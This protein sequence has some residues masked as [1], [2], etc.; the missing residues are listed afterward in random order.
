MK[1]QQMLI[2]KK[3]IAI[4]VF[5]I[6][7]IISVNLWFYRSFK[8]QAVEVNEYVKEQAVTR[9]SDYYQQIN[10]FVTGNVNTEDFERVQNLS[11]RELVY[12]SQNAVNIVKSLNTT[13]RASSLL[14][15]VYIYLKKPGLIICRS[16]I[17][18][19][20][21]FYEIEGKTR[22][23]SFDEWQDAIINEGKGRKFTSSENSVIFAFAA[24][25]IGIDSGIVLGTITS[26]EKIFPKTPHVEWINNCNI[27]VYD[28][29]KN[30]SLY[31]ENI[32]I[33]DFTQIPSY[34]KLFGISD[35]YVLY[36]Y[37]V[38][39]SDMT[40]NVNVVFE[41]N[42]DMNIV[43]SVQLVL[44]AMMAFLILSMMYFFYKIYTTR[45]RPI[46]EI[47]DLLG[48]D[49]DK[50]DYRVLE[51]PIKSIVDKNILLNNMLEDKD[52]R[53]KMTILNGLLNGDIKKDVLESED[54]GISFKF[55]GFVVIVINLYRD[56]EISEEEN[57]KLIKKFE[58][59]ITETISDENGITY[60]VSRKQYLVCIYNTDKSL[61][62]NWLGLKFAYLTKILETEFEFVA[63]IAI[64]DIHEGYLQIPMAYSEALE[65]IN[66]VELF[67]KSK[68][69][70]YRDV[71]YKNN[72]FKFDINDEIKL[73]KAIRNGNKNAAEKIIGNVIERIDSENT[74]TYTNIS[75][76]LIY[77]LMRIADL[78][79]GENY[80]TSSISLLLKSTEDIESLKASLVD[81]AAKMCD[82]NTYS[83]EQGDLAEIIMDYVR[84]NYDNPQMS[85]E[86]ISNN[87]NY[88][89]V[90][91]HNVFRKKYNKTI[92][93]CL[94]S[95]RIE[96][97]KKLILAGMKIGEVSEKVGI[98]SVRTFNRLFQN[99]VGMTPTEYKEYMLKQ[100]KEKED[101]NE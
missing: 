1:K 93:S 80:D 46:K 70:F 37:E 71:I 12:R 9:I 28:R 61:D 27:Y 101:N 91:I 16:G 2:I 21:L 65:V 50:I 73:T 47:S 97:A 23:K 33:K 68:I 40:Y 51:K 92:V 66:K 90:H 22:V 5:L 88:S 34:D 11:E 29:Y 77:S 20:E 74:F 76:G 82:D 57:K 53:L 3:Y 42:Q 14:D 67:D 62:L 84:K 19:P 96:A 41:K 94:N 43:K 13:E 4:T 69:A 30:L 100:S 95:F 64:S 26:R 79:F 54:S 45:M 10:S 8:H 87:L 59:A 83:E 36:S 38:M 60:F 49:I 78:L 35:K 99:S 75:V 63:S 72:R 39:V 15:K 98:A 81:F 56:S 25:G 89:V 18:D 24:N 48:I 85:V 58:D 86:F 44:N 6:L 7:V 32:K 31:N 17:L 52:T 55:D